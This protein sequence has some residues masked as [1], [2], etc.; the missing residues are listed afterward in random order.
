MEHRIE[1]FELVDPII[2]EYHCSVVLY[3]VDPHCRICSTRNV[4]P[5]QH[6]WWADAAINNFFRHGVPC[7]TSA[8]ITGRTDDWPMGVEEARKHRLETVKEWHWKDMARYKGM[9]L[10]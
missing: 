9:S 6:D 3:L 5:Q 8:E 1:P 7:E 4:P 10:Y 2:S